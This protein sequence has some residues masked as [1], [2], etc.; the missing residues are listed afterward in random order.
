MT[1]VSN[2]ECFK[3]NIVRY[4]LTKDDYIQRAFFFAPLP[5]LELI[6][7]LVFRY[8]SGLYSK[9]QFDTKISALSSYYCTDLV[10]LLRKI[11]DYKDNPV[12]IRCEIQKAKN[13]SI[14]IVERN[15]LLYLNLGFAKVRVDGIVLFISPL[16]L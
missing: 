12:P 3:Q 8:Y 11:T 14:P 1:N 6:D 4:Y 16:H 2:E 13:N 5:D 15:Q 10:N 7:S 9:I